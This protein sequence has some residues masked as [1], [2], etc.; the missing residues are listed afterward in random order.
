MS[1]KAS[2]AF[3]ALLRRWL[4]E[5]EQQG[6]LKNGLN[7]GEIADFLVI[8]LNGAVPLYVASKDPVIW[9]QTMAQLHFYIKSLRKSA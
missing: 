8:A 2:R 4:E 9:Q 5:A 3:S 7:L 6:R 1:C